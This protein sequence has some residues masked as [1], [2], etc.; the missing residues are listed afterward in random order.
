MKLVLVADVSASPEGDR[1]VGAEA[2]LHAA[3]AQLELRGPVTTTL[4]GGTADSS[5]APWSRSINKIPVPADSQA[6]AK[7]LAAVAGAAAGAADLLDPEDDAWG[8]I[9]AIADC[10]AVLVCGGGNLTSRFSQLVHERHLITTLS[11]TFGK[12]L[13]FTG[14]AV[15]PEL[16]P[17]S[18]E[19]ISEALSQAD[20]V[21]CRDA[22][23]RALA[24][25][26]GVSSPIVHTLDDAAYAP[27]TT[28][29]TAMDDLTVA[30]GYAVMTLP[31]DSGQAPEARWPQS[32]ADA[33]LAIVER[34]GLDVV[35]VPHTGRIGESVDDAAM[36]SQIVAL[37]D[38]PRVR[39]AQLATVSQTISLT[40]A[41]SLVVSGRLHPL[42]FA[43]A[44]SVPCIGIYTDDYTHQK[45]AGELANYGLEQ[46]ALPALSLPSGGFDAALEAIWSDRERFSAHVDQ[47]GTSHRE[48]SAEW[49]D[50]VVAVLGGEEAP[51]PQLT[52]PETLLNDSDWARSAE[53][54]GNWLH[55]WSTQDFDNGLRTTALAHQVEELSQKVVALD[56]E[57][58][59]ARAREFEI[60]SS[61]DDAIVA[62]ERAQSV[63]AELG[64]PV[65][66]AITR[67]VVAEV[68][69]SRSHQVRRARTRIRRFVKKI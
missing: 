1:N 30:S 59:A 3:V 36:T 43:L 18:N 15:G 68:P 31:A 67:P 62:A 34:T 21:G 33:A 4:L 12:P 35:L 16:V 55:E 57:L 19:L 9:D 38:S 51:I 14:Q 29:D 7:R 2:T 61:R 26:L 23:S 10:D 52:Q 56:N 25:Q 63:V 66:A 45:I 5:T 46:L 44:A 8:I 6:Y 54:L 28:D 22:T 39:S 49:W 17:N 47:I 58:A 60:R 20:L 40:Q 37:C 53:E 24:L 41:A 13:V 64:K 27:T 11:K 48:S 65:Y 50:L 42:V 69:R 32:L